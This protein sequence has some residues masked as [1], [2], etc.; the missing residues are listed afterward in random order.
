MTM[1]LVA[2]H[3]TK[4]GTN[5]W[6]LSVWPLAKLSHLGMQTF[7]K[8]WLPP[9]CCL[10]MRLQAQWFKD[11]QHFTVDLGDHAISNKCDDFP[12]FLCVQVCVT[13]SC[14]ISV[15][16]GGLQ[17]WWI[18]MELTVTELYSNNDRSLYTV[19]VATHTAKYYFDSQI[20]LYCLW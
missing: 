5:T 9:L 2:K 10:L 8:I 3:S 4:T 16:T 14:Y 13:L 18:N 20:L 7:T 1:P 11:V 12:F 17:R 6:H 15:Y 19:T